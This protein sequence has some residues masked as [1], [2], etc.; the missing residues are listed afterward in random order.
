MVGRLEGFML[1]DIYV[2][3][4]STTLAEQYSLSLAKH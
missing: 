3:G 2:E 1:N 4:S